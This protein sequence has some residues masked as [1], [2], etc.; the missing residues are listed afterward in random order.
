M[1]DTS[2]IG[3][4][5]ASSGLTGTEAFAID[6]GAATEKITSAQIA[7]FVSA[8]ISV[9]I[10][11]TT[12]L[13]NSSGAPSVPSALTVSQVN[14]LLGSISVNGV[15][16]LTNKSIDGLSNTLT[17]LP[18]AALTGSLTATAVSGQWSVVN[19]GTGAATLSGIL[20]GNGTSAI[21]SAL[22]TDIV[23]TFSG[24]AD[25]NH[26]MAGD[27]TLQALVVGSPSNIQ[28]FPNAAGSGTW[29]KP[30]GSP[31]TTRVMGTG[32]GGAGGGGPQIASGTA[33]CGGAGGGGGFWQDI[34]F[35]PSIL[36]ATETVTVGAGGSAGTAGSAGNGGNGGNG[37]ATSFGTWVT[38]SGGGGGQGG[39]T[40]NNVG[41]GGAGPYG[42]GLGGSSGGTSGGPG[43]GA[44]G[45]SGA[46]GGDATSGS[47]A[48][49]GADANSSGGAAGGNS[50]FG[51]AGGGAG[52][53]LATSPAGLAGGAGGR[54][55][56]NSLTA[57][58]GG[59]AST[60]GGTRTAITGQYLAGL[61]GGGGGSSTNATAG[62]GGAGSRG[63]GGGGGGAALTTTAT[64]GA[65][66]VGG[67]G[68]CVVITSF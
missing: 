42:P 58:A 62:T 14:T 10:P 40:A 5:P 29:T 3:N 20:K 24:T 6:T 51:G 68:Y 11:A 36:G 26:Y 47:G 35:D 21:G 66:G 4:L 45:T 30:G 13:G 46:K 64:A 49:G 44:G 41:G 1:V 60:G 15:A 37:A 12:L 50:I 54:N 67:D 22:S 19:G 65:G 59:G 16:T 39:Q 43:A 55:A 52:G 56:M 38:A 32:G 53:G 28:L 8:Q 18:A 25:V 48:G 27:G 2:T 31:K 33:C 17:D 7:N 23:A 34:T 9:P 63:G 57:A 61:G